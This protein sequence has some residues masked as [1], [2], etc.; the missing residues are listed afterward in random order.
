MFHLR[1]RPLAG[2]SSSA[3]Y[4]SA[5]PGRSA[6]VVDGLPGLPGDRDRRRDRRAPRRPLVP[7]ELP[8]ALL[9]EPG[10]EPQ[11][12]DPPLHGLARLGL[13]PW[14][15]R[16]IFRA[17][18]R[19]AR[20]SPWRPSRFDSAG[21]GARFTGLLDG[22]ERPTGGLL[23][24]LCP[25]R[26]RAP[27]AGSARHGTTARSGAR[28]PP[29]RG[30]PAD[31]GEGRGVRCRP[32]APGRT[33]SMETRVPREAGGLPGRGLLAAPALATLT[34]MKVQYPTVSPSAELRQVHAKPWTE[35]ILHVDGKPVG[36]RDAVLNRLQLAEG[37][38]EEDR[39]LMAAGY[40]LPGS[41]TR[42][43]PDPF[44]GLKPSPSWR[45]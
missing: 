41:A 11:D 10:A 18:R 3:R 7:G 36:T 5:T 34:A 39:A 23:A 17:S 16:A 35:Y 8:V 43:P 44:G 38:P 15:T 45:Q 31:S 9:E 14:K 33:R 6:D 22:E 1:S 27:R 25:G 32:R 12:E 2:G 26:P 4:P 13:P 30:E 21:R 19:R 28:R 42:P 29:G 24:V 37:T 20:Q 40:L